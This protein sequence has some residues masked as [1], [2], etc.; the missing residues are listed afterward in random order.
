MNGV[1]GMLDL[2]LRAE[3]DSDQRERLVVARNSARHLL[4]ILNDIL[5]LSKLEANR[6][7]LE[8]ADVDV[9]RLARDV[10]ALMGTGAR[11]RDLE[12]TVRIAPAVPPCLFCDATRLRQVMLNLVSNA[13]K[14]TEVGGVELRLDYVGDGQ[15]EVAVTDTGIGIPADAMEHLFRRFAQVDSLPA[16]RREGTGLGLAISR[17]LVELMGGTIAVESVPGLGSTFS[18]RIPAPP[19]IRRAAVEPATAA[20]DPLPVAVPP[21]RILVAEDNATN[22]T[23]LAAYL[24]MAGHEVRMVA[25]GL[26]ALT[27]LHCG[28][29]DLVLLDVQMPM[30]DGITATRRIRAIPGPEAAL[31]VIALTA[32]ATPGDREACLAAGMTD[33]LTKPVSLEALSAAIA[34]CL[35]YSPV[36]STTLQ[37][38]P[39]SKLSMASATA[40]VSS[41]RSAS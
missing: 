15:L 33:F 17:E 35:A 18:F 2:I 41:P 16:R 9:H 11:D 12:V 39:G 31:P 3:D 34:R 32:S 28:S 6:T 26:E 4:S 23:I 22:R 20:P 24:G 36:S 27:A 25:N 40:R 5:D 30:M 8:P 19:A 14:F 38:S 21:A 7:T 37:P 29:F 13:V 10:V 1:I